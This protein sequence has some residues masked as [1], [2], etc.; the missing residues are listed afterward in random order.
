MYRQKI[1]DLQSE[2]ISLISLKVGFLLKDEGSRVMLSSSFCIDRDIND[3]GGFSD[4]ESIVV[5][6]LG[7]TGKK[8][9][10][11]TDDGGHL[12]LEESDIYNLVGYL[13][14]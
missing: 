6:S 14:S 7:R 9:F 12:E 10:F 11:I 2:M 13:I 1:Q 5:S 8:T 3:Y 4:T